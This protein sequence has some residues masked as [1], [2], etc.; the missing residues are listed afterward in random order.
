M[1]L[2]NIVKIGLKAIDDFVR[3]KKD[4]KKIAVRH[5]KIR[6]DLRLSLSTLLFGYGRNRMSIIKDTIIESIETK[7]RLFNDESL[8]KTIEEAADSIETAL[9]SGKK[10][11]IG[12]N[13]GSE[14]DSL[15]FAGEIVGRFLRERD[16][17]SAIV[18]GA[19]VASLTAIANDYG[20]G[21]AYA[22][23]AK[24]YTQEGDVL[25]AISTSGNSENL[26]QAILAIKG[27]S[28]T[29]IGLLGRDGGKL[30][31]MVDF[32]IVVPSDITARIQESH[33]TIIHILCDLVERGMVEEEIAG[34]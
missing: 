28:C 18:L 22:R 14:S 16:P 17:W 21:K 19:N 29:T 6:E 23:E 25:I 12:G 26:V 27:V 5:P 8:I 2:K 4:L 11:I 13:G 9:K 1:R 32:P 30:R 15:H 3:F 20:Y 31:D 10:L 7:Q 34:R 33:I 24:A